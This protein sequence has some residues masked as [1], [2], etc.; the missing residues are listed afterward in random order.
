MC[1]EYVCVICKQMKDNLE[2]GCHGVAAVKNGR[3]FMLVNVCDRCFERSTDIVDA[4]CAGSLSDHEF[5][6]ASEE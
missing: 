4:C 5:L 2:D 3:Q 6:E 1:V